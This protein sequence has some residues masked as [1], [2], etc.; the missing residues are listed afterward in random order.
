MQNNVTCCSGDPDDHSGP[1][2]PSRVCVPSQ[3]R[4]L[5][6]QNPLIT[7]GTRHNL[8]LA[9]CIHTWRL[10]HAYTVIHPT[11]PRACAHETRHSVSHFHVLYTFTP[12]LRCV[13]DCCCLWQVMDIRVVSRIHARLVYARR[14]AHLLH[15]HPPAQ[16]RTR[17][18]FIG[19]G[20]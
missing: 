14:Y 9:P 3:F 17:H 19:L 2:L 13:V 15:R 5:S 6:R 16:T 4:L 7:V 8:E 12:S 1:L 11:L 20:I 18:P 10:A